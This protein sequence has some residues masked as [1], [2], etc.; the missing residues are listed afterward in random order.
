MTARTLILVRHG[1]AQSRNLGI[2]D[3]ERTLTKAGVQA[4]RA[5]LP[6]SAKL[7]KALFAE[8][9]EEMAEKTSLV[10]K[11]DVADGG[12]DCDRAAQGA[13]PSPI[14]IWASPTAR[15]RQTAREVV[16]AYSCDIPVVE[17]ES[18]L[19][20]DFAAFCG[21]LAAT[22][23]PCVIAVGHN[24]F[25]EDVLACLCGARLDCATGAV[26]AVRLPLR[27]EEWFAGEVDSADS[28]LTAEA[29]GYFDIPPMA[30]VDC[31]AKNGAEAASAA[32]EGVASAAEL[33]TDAPA[34]SSVRANSAP[35]VSSMPGVASPFCSPGGASCNGARL[36]WFV[37]GPQSQRWKARA[38][39]EDKVQAGCDAVEARLEAF[40]AS[41]DDVET[42]HKLRVSIR[43]LRSL[44]AFASPFLRR[45]AHKALQRN[46]RDVVV[47]TSR[48]RE[49]DVLLKQAADLTVPAEELC[50][51]VRLARESERDQVVRALSSKETARA[52]AF[53][54]KGVERMP[55]TDRVKREG[56]VL[57]QACQRFDEMAC[58]VD[59]G[60]ETV[61]FADADAV[62]TLRKQA[63]RVRYAAENF[64][65][66]LGADVAEEA[67]RMVG[68]QDRLGAV[69]DARVNV[70][71][72]CEF[73][74]EGLSPE[75]RRALGA[76]LEQNM[77]FEEAFLRDV[78]RSSSAAGE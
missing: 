75:A 7:A 64:P 33:T 74:T 60:F 52:L 10:A 19:R 8:A 24:P 48:L 9:K 51:A 53:V 40:L 5:W 37:Q 26:A 38:A 23:T 28:H 17:H 18:L 22:T 34:V 58:T 15:T 47:Q 29:Q 61:D 1:K 41:P 11:T 73:P 12:E 35:G 20:Q 57:E 54:R 3:E 68:V 78:A 49:Y 69:C 27:P 14:E 45:K 62:H 44:L 70:G 50:A 21:E 65:E 46:L 76:L 16:R 66:I 42:L 59:E 43:T 71:I 56:V 6:Q 31:L 39:I 4:L 55:W 13:A 77:A 30:G 25:M 63:K 2:P 32:H 36:L 72:V 67:R